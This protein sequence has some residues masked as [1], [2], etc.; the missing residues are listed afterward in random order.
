MINIQSSSDFSS[1]EDEKE[2]EAHDDNELIETGL[3]Y[4]NIDR[5]SSLLKVNF[6]GFF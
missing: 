4:S 1:N 3:N 2:E 5:F 6:S